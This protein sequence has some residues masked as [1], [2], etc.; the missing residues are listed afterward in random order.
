MVKPL[1][2]SAFQRQVRDDDAASAQT[3]IVESKKMD[4]PD[5]TNPVWEEYGKEG[6]EKAAPEIKRKGTS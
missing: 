3:E 4:R 2:P 1:S 6:R 5:E